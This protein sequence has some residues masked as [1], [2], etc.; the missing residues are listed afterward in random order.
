MSFDMATPQKKRRVAGDAEAVH[1]LV[2]AGESAASGDA[3]Y[4]QEVFEQ[5]PA[6]AGY[7]R[8]LWEKGT[9]K[10]ALAKYL[11]VMGAPSENKLGEKLSQKALTVGSLPRT[12]I[13]KLAFRAIEQC[14]GKDAVTDKGWVM[15]DAHAHN[16]VMF[17]LQTTRR[18]PLSFD[19]TYFPE[20]EGSMALVLLKHIEVKGNLLRTMTPEN[21]NLFGYFCIHADGPSKVMCC[22]WP[23]IAADTPL[24]PVLIDTYDDWAIF[25]NMTHA[26]RLCSRKADFGVG[27]AN[28]F[29]KQFEMTL[30]TLEDQISHPRAADSLKDE[31]EPGD[32]ALKIGPAAKAAAKA[33]AGPKASGK[34][35]APSRPKKKKPVP[36]DAVIA[37][38]VE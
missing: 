30:P 3:V 6:L 13:W 31:R 15:S 38:P 16:T 23:G 19:A 27:L 7:I 2:K 22:F 33:K 18:Q 9:L 1:A 26:A 11:G 12:F 32:E 10:S 34:S 8:S 25:D 5:T 35:L 24:S 4:M 21:A 36:T 29:E 14:S 17:A 20:Y 28:L 37:E